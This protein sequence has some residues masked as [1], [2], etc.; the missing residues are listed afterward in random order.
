ILKASAPTL[1]VALA[2]DS[3]TPESVGTASGMVM[4]MHY[5]AAVV[6]PIVAARLIT[7]TG[8]MIFTM[9]LT[10]TVPLILYGGL[11]ALA[12]DNRPVNP[13]PKI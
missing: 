2:Q 4:S 5:V 3:A 8:D 11:I 7:G 6:A 13:D 1:V 12:R 10:S 9:I